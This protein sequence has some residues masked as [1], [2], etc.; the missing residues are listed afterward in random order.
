MTQFSVILS[1]CFVCGAW[2]TFLIGVI[3]LITQRDVSDRS[4][5]ILGCVTWRRLHFNQIICSINWIGLTPSLWMRCMLTIWLVNNELSGGACTRKSSLKMKH[6]HPQTRW[7]KGECWQ[8]KTRK[9]SCVW[10]S[11][12]RFSWDS[13]HL[14]SCRPL[15]RLRD[16]TLDE[17]CFLAPNTF[18]L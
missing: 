1:L 11:E 7:S 10:V 3:D 14:N 2:T 5:L 9:R 6:P 12:V 15:I 4:M 8:W 16:H 18:S 13:S 17:I